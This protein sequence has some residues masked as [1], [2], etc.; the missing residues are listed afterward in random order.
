[1]TS[2]EKWIDLFEKV[3]G[4]K[5]T[6]LE[7]Q[8]GKSL[9]FDLKAI[10][11]IAAKESGESASAP[12][13]SADHLATESSPETDQEEMFS[14]AE[15]V[16]DVAEESFE[17]PISADAELA[18]KELT[19]PID[20]SKEDMIAS[21]S[22]DV[23]LKA[24]TTY[25]GR[26]PQPEEFMIGKASGFDV[27]TIHQFI[28]DN[29]STVSKK[30]GMAG[31]KKALIVF[32]VILS[33]FGIAGY[34]YGYQYY[35]REAVAERYLKAVKKDF[36]DS[37]DYQV[38]SDTEK[39]I[40][41]SDLKYTDTKTVAKYTKDELLSGSIMKKVGRKFLIFADWKVVVEPV[42]V[43]LAVNTADLAVTIN[44]VKY[45]TTDGNNYTATIKHLYPGSYD[46]VASGKVDE[47]DI[48]VSTEETVTSNTDVDLS[49]EYLSFTVKSN[50]TDGDLYV[51]STKIGTLTSGKLEVDDVAVT[52]SSAVYVQKSFE[53]GTASKTETVSIDQIASGQTITLDAEGILDRDTADD[54]MEVAYTKLQYYSSNDNTTPDGLTDVFLNGSEDSLYKDVTAMI[55]ENTTGAQNRAADSITF[56]DVDVTQVKQTSEK[57]YTIT[58]TVVYDFYYA[59]DSNFKTSGHIKQKKSWSANVEYVSGEKSKDRGSYSATSSD[60]RVS[61]KAGE[62]T[63]ISKEDTVK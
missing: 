42:N 63:E 60:Y 61:G 20:E 36:N 28:S 52:G 21:D 23:W 31:W 39:V 53:D 26:Q 45:D 3:V 54:L 49:V 22:Q 5:P 17:E 58:F 40:K 12:L 6:A 47:Q 33:L 7:F 41:K 57:T 35:S 15:D 62:S 30:S 14:T 27:S 46:F 50:L 37:L 32:A 48:T 8:E 38:W 34:V 51:G 43:N 2:Q 1:M 25:V 19:N 13:F 11:R 4:R 59:Y 24:F 56:S 55:D 10:K 29:K 44:G 9:D 18:S 16:F